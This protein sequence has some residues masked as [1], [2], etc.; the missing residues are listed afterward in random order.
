VRAFV[1]IVLTAA[2]T[3]IQTTIDPPTTTTTTLAPTSTT[4]PPCEV[5]PVVDAT[6]LAED[7]NQLSLLVS[8]TAYPCSD[9]AVLARG[10]D[11]KMLAAA[12]LA[13]AIS[14]PL[15][16]VD[17][18]SSEATLETERLGAEHVYIVGDI[19]AVPRA[20]V[21]VTRL[22]TDQALGRTAELLG[23]VPIID[24]NGTASIGRATVAVL[25]GQS[26]VRSASAGDVADSA[27]VLNEHPLDRPTV[28]LGDGSRFDFLAPV[29]AAAAGRGEA[30]LLI[31]PADLR[32]LNDTIAAYRSMAPTTTVLAAG[33]EPRQA[34]WQ[35]PA[36]KSA[37]EL[38][39]GGIM[40]FPGRRLVA[41][42][43]NPTTSA[44]GVLGEQGPEES[45]VRVAEIA[46]GYDADGIPI[47][48]SFEIIATVA[49]AFAG[50]DNDYSEEMTLD[51]LMPWI[52][53]AAEQGVYV[54][55][56]LQPGRTDFLTQAKRYEELLRFPHV[57]LAL[58]P[59]WRLEPDQVH[60]RQIGSVDAAEVN[61]VSEWL[62]GIVRSENLPQ[63]FFL[64]HQFRLD[65]ITN[66]DQVK[67]PPELA[68]VVQMDGQGPI[69]TKYDT[70]AALTA[71]A[72]DS[73][74]EW[75]WKNFYDED[76]PRGGLT[77]EQVLE[78]N[79]VPVY[80]SFQ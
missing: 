18:D 78:L 7:P 37:P 68:V 21:S 8:R 56:D 35:L 70:W 61:S 48:P 77:A 13:A 57:G 58:D 63:K 34:E 28:W 54:I 14:A 3:G 23:G 36:F 45:V 31:D 71:G 64:L 69:H 41:L 10:D 30:L 67:S 29:L 32:R 33:L 16:L 27:S 40:F 39:G 5:T 1:L 76:I 22:T 79:P 26:V 43:G 20:G 9:E 59:E 25:T 53:V 4:A 42:Y 55:L 44:L 12:Q 24:E 2:C 50:S 47:L 6:L 80:V 52:E 49:S 73:D 75:G 15:L 66:R 11:A 74:W 65:M 60:L 19:I 62:A 38:P 17:D 46:Q 51:Q 72:L